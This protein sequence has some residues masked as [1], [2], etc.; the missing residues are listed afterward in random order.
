MNYSIRWVHMLACTH[1]FKGMYQQ[2]NLFP[3]IA[4]L[5]SVTACTNLFLFI[6]VTSWEAHSETSFGN[7]NHLANRCL[8]KKTQRYHMGITSVRYFWIFIKPFLMTFNTNNFQI[9]GLRIGFWGTIHM[10]LAKISVLLRDVAETDREFWINT[11][12]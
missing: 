8:I 1:I 11:W 10:T 4:W 9:K 2:Y 6:S 3:F 7:Y 5:V 12:N